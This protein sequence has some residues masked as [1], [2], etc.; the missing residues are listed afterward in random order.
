MMVRSKILDSF[1]IFIPKVYSTLLVQCKVGRKTVFKEL[2]LNKIQ[3]A[4][5]LRNVFK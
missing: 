5:K 4:S 2:V 1:K 3:N